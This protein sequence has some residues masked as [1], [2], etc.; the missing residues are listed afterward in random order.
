MT[1]SRGLKPDGLSEPI[2]DR[3]VPAFSS[4]MPDTALLPAVPAKPSAPLDANTPPAV[5][6][7]G[8]SDALVAGFA[9]GGPVDGT[10]GGTSSDR[11][12]RGVGDPLSWARIKDSRAV[13]V[14]AFE[15]GGA[16]KE[17]TSLVSDP[18]ADDVD[19][20]VAVVG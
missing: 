18:T 17:R 4:S 12:S 15:A 19:A 14:E 8:G 5:P 2:V 10:G 6:L 13:A 9:C 1:D 7:K 11:P 3:P 20:V 16:D